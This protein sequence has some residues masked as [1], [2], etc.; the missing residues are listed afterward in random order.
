VF[1]ARHSHNVLV[2]LWRMASCDSR[3][4]LP[5][6]VPRLATDNSKSPAI[7]LDRSQSNCS[8][9]FAAATTSAFSA[10][11]SHQPTQ[12]FTDSSSEDA[13]TRDA[14]HDIIRAVGIPR[15]AWQAGTPPPAQHLR[16]PFQFARKKEDS[17]A[18]HFGAKLCGAEVAEKQTLPQ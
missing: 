17:R 18:S 4:S 13:A 8:A 2:M 15:H 11:F 9:C 1:H 14:I 5:W 7:V 16:M 12:R 10:R 3:N 6:G